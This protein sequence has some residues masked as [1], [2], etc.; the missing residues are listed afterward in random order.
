LDIDSSQATTRKVIKPF[1][2]WPSD[3]S[4]EMITRAAPGLN[5]LHS[6]ADKL[7]WVESRPWEAGR[8][9]IMCKTPDG[10]IK[11]LLPAQFS[12]NSKVHEYGGM[13]YTVANQKLYFVNA[14]D[15]RIYQLD[16]ESSNNP[17]PVSPEGPFRF[18]DIIVDTKNQRLIAVCEHHIEGQE[19]DNYIAAL[20]LDQKH[21]QA[22]LSC[23]F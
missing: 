16:L 6:S 22:N 9:V 1:G 18:A 5:H 3:I 10:A 21:S 8:N 19:P 20:A 7:F 14:L 4:A 2:T 12:C 13:A 15:Q 23:G 17:S 11:D